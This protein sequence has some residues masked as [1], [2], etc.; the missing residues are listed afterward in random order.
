MVQIGIG[1]SCLGPEAVYKA[2]A[3]YKKQGRRVHFLS[4]VDPDDAAAIFREVDLA[5]TVIVVVSKSGTT[6]ETLTNEA[7]AKELLQKEGLDVR[8]HLIA[9]TGKGSPMDDPSLYREV[10]YI[11]DYIGGRYSATSMIG[12]FSL[13]FALGMDRLIEFLK[14]ANSM[15]KIALLDDRERNLPLS[16]CSSRHL[17]PQFHGT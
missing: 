6:L 8:Q 3:A 9:I 12:A 14:G 17:E 13:A 7:F 15:D 11:W 2:L 1:G 5:K 10:L 16:L 4:N